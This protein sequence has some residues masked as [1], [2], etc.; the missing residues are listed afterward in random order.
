MWLAVSYSGTWQCKVVFDSGDWVRQH[1][2]QL[3]LLLLLKILLLLLS[4]VM[5][6]SSEVM[7]HL[8]IAVALAGALDD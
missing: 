2:E 6:H 5:L 8:L 4:Q 3:L 7:M 1:S